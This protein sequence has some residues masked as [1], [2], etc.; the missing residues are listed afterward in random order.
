MEASSTQHA[1]YLRA[2]YRTRRAAGQ[3]PQCGNK[4]R[5]GL[6]TCEECYQAQSLSHRKRHA[7]RFER[8]LC[9]RCGKEPRR[10]NRTLGENCAAK[11]KRGKVIR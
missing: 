7:S 8:G 5:D 9:A 2:L 10:P 4:P 11:R 1:V 6:A 3:C